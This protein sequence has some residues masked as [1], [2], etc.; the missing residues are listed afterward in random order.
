MGHTRPW[1]IALVAFCTLLTASGQ[2]LFKMGVD[3]VAP[4][5]IGI[6]TNLQLIGG[7]LIYGLGAAILI[8]ALKYGELSVLYP[9]IA[10]SFVWVL[11]LSSA[12]LGEPV[13]I[14]RSVG[15]FSIILGVSSIGKGSKNGGKLKLR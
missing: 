1:A 11:I 15:V 13:G 6:I 10:L 3:S 4:T 2:L 8:V 5:F 12:V 9:V 14:M 7:F